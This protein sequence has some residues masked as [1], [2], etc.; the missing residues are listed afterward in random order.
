MF[1]VYLR[2]YF[3]VVVGVVNRR[4]VGG[5]A[6]LGFGLSLGGVLL[7]SILGSLLGALFGVPSAAR[8][9][10]LNLISPTPAAA[11]VNACPTDLPILADRLVRDFPGYFN[12]AIVRGRLPDHA[13]LTTRVIATSEP[14]FPLASEQAELKKQGIESVFFTTLERTDRQ[15]ERVLRQ[16]FYQLFF[17]QDVA[18]W[19]LVTVRSS[20]GNYPHLTT[21]TAPEE[22]SQGFVA[23]AVRTWL[24]DCA[25]GALGD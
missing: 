11:H 1:L 16:G 10:T 8:S 19:I 13:A 4:G 15:G 9:T 7:G 14:D 21:V 2:A 12:R 24:T 18:G 3:C 17:T 25:A 5:A 20:S 6:G 22:T 23:Q